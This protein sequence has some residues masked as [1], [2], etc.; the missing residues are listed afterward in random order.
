MLSKKAIREPSSMQQTYK[1][2]V[3][4]LIALAGSGLTYAAL[5]LVGD[6]AVSHSRIFEMSSSNRLHLY[7]YMFAFTPFDAIVTTAIV[8]HTFFSR[9]SSPSPASSLSKSSFASPPPLTSSSPTRPAI[10][11]PIPRSPDIA[12]IHEPEMSDIGCETAMLARLDYVYEGET[13]G[14]MSFER[15]PRRAPS[16]LPGMRISL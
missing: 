8:F 15:P 2:V 12:S 10:S 5:C 4:V 1:R 11:S 3:L 14:R 6:Y 16:L 13:A 7:L 9:S